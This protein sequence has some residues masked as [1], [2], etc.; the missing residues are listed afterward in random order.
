VFNLGNITK[1]IIVGT[2]R[3]L[4]IVRYITNLP[5]K[6]QAL[7]ICLYFVGCVPKP[8]GISNYLLQRCAIAFDAHV[9]KF[10][11]QTRAIYEILKKERESGNE[12]SNMK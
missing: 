12:K 4:K 8:I 3:Y 1:D 2:V 9:D 6:I 11:R 5:L 10:E 7:I